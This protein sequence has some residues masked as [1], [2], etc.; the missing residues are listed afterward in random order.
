MYPVIEVIE[1]ISKFSLNTLPSIN[2]IARL[3]KTQE[4]ALKI[5]VSETRPVRKKKPKKE[6]ILND[7]EIIIT[8]LD[9]LKDAPMESGDEI[10][11]I[12]KSFPGAKIVEPDQE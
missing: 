9:E 11:L 10:S 5:L 1:L 12:N 2:H 4:T 6:T 3:E 8:N 7:E